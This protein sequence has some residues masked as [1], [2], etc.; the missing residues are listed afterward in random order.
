MLRYQKLN[1]ISLFLICLLYSFS[2]SAELKQYI[3]DYSYTAE[4]FDSKYTCRI[5]AIDGVKQSLLE[6]LG[7]YVQSVIKVNENSDGDRYV[8][9]DYVTL[10]A[11]ILSTEILQEDWDRIAYYVKARIKVDPEE[12]QRALAA[13]KKDVRLE[14]AL[15][16]SLHELGEARKNIEKLQQEMQ[17]QKNTPAIAALNQQYVKAAQ[18]LEVEYQYQHAIRAIVDGNF[19]E[20][21]SLLNKLAEKNYARA[22]SKLGHMYERGMGLEVDYGK[23]AKFYLQSIKNGSATAMARLGF[24]YERGLG[25]RRDVARAIKLYQQAVDRGNYQGQSRLAELYLKGIGVEKDTTKA[26]QLISDSIASHKHGRGY[27]LMGYMYELGLEFE[28]DYKQAAAWYDKAA[29]RGNAKGMARLAWLYAKGRGVEENYNKAWALSRH[30]E[31]YNNPFA[32]MVMGYMYEKGLGVDR[33]RQEAIELYNRS[34]KQNSAAAMFRLGNAYQKG[35]GVDEDID[36]AIIWF[37]RAS[38]RG[39]KGSRKRLAKLLDNYEEY[40]DF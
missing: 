16:D 6:E 15:R 9:H 36:E 38:E 18:N 26:L 24:L 39:H 31:K 28:K 11:G 23:A 2:V 10:T 14:Q 4:E 17:R 25:V 35:K 40:R 20:A 1:A 34:A 29:Q 27:A 12:V 5:R 7:T 22:Q 3:R 19:K 21:F 33:N 8:E 30:A 37:R 32:L 13:L